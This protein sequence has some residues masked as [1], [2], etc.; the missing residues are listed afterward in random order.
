[1]SAIKKKR[2]GSQSVPAFM[3]DRIQ[4]A[5]KRFVA[6]E[7]EA[8]KLLKELI[9]RGK[10]SRKELKGLLKRA[11]ELEIVDRAD[12]LRGRAEKT[13]AQVVRRLEELQDRALGLVGVASQAQVEELSAEIDKL[14]KK[15]DRLGKAARAKLTSKQQR[16][17]PPA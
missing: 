4:D 1:M 8:Q 11:G 9:S 6:F 16:A 5:E 12:E 15:I 7:E 10:T 14:S 3:K 17:L 2:N 13:G